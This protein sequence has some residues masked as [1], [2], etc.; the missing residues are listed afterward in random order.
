[1]KKRSYLGFVASS[2][3]VR[4]YLG[5]PPQALSAI[6]DGGLD[7]FTVFSFSL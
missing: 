1:M 6:M 5:T 4:V 7:L 2:Y 3:Y